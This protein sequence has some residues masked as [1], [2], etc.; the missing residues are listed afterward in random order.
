MLRKGSTSR[1]LVNENIGKGF[2]MEWFEKRMYSVGTTKCET[3]IFALD[4]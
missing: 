3:Y 1:G 4:V 2:G